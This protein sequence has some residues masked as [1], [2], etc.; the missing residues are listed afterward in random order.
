M[1]EHLREEPGADAGTRDAQGRRY[2]G[3][4]LGQHAGP[5]IWFTVLV[6]SLGFTVGGVAIVYESL[7][8]FIIGAAI[9]VVA[10]IASLFAGIMNTTE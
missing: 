4:K 2:G 3:E 5:L 7:T 10:G 9:F 8:W 1:S 6:M